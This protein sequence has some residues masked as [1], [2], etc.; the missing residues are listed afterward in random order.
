MAFAKKKSKRR[1]QEGGLSGVVTSD[2]ERGK[3]MEKK[4]L[5]PHFRA[6]TK[7]PERR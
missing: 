5:G 1:E 2:N 7:R 4:R 6:V 3:R